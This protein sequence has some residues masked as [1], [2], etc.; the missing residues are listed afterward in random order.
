MDREEI[1]ETLKKVEAQTARNSK[2]SIIPKW[3]DC[4]PERIWKEEKCNESS[5]F[6][7]FKESM[8]GWMVL[9]HTPLNHNKATFPASL[10]RK[11]K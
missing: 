10:M 5:C 2:R 3:R 9:L 11:H 7:P 6:K 1:R 8:E 4:E